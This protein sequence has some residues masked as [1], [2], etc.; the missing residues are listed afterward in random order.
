MKIRSRTNATVPEQFKPS[1]MR[2]IDQVLVREELYYHWLL[3]KLRD[4]YGDGSGLRSIGMYFWYPILLYTGR[5]RNQQLLINLPYREAS[6][7]EEWSVLSLSSNQDDELSDSIPTGKL[8]CYLSAKGISFHTK[9]GVQPVRT[10]KH[11]TCYSIEP[12]SQR[13]W[14]IWRGGR[15]KNRMYFIVSR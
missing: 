13:I 4:L 1:G 6:S 7:F 15:G 9:Q 12:E 8:R 14:Q 5:P 3:R 2:E 11:S 10:G